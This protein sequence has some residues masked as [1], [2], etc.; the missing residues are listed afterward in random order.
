MPAGSAFESAPVTP[1]VAMASSYAA[2]SAW[3]GSRAPATDGGR[4]EYALHMVHPG[5]LH[6][7]HFSGELE[8]ALQGSGPPS[9]PQLDHGH[10]GSAGG[11]FSHPAVNWSL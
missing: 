2:P 8:L 10:A 5:S 7:G 1:S 4:N 11:T 3:A 9:Q 6:H